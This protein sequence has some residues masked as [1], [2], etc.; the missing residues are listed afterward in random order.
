[1]IKLHIILNSTILYRPVE[2]FAALPYGFTFSSKPHRIIYALHCAM[3]NG[4]MFFD[5]LNLAS[6]VD[7]ENITLI[8][9]S[10]GNGFFVN[11]AFEHQADFLRE[12]LVPALQ[13]KLNL[14]ADPQ[15]TF[16]LGISMGAYGAMR[17]TLEASDCFGAVAAISGIYDPLMS[18]DEHIGKNKNLWPLRM[19]FGGAMQ[20]LVLNQNGELQAD[21]DIKNLLASRT[22]DGQALP[23]FALFCGDKDYLS[24]NQ[25]KALATAFS[26]HDVTHEI[27]VTPGGHDLEYWQ[28]IIPRV[29]AWLLAD[30]HN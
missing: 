21:A 19:I 28:R 6:Y 3:K 1:M 4:D 5:D 9:P 18:P 13:E 22:R 27:T 15:H 20:K 25:T 14:R 10:L 29:L 7:R 23:R 11:S 8:A 16:L 17:L 26:L 30:T 24:L 12:E 2:I